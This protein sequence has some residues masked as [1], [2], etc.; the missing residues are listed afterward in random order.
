MRLAVQHLWM[1]QAG[2]TRAN[3]TFGFSR[4]TAERVH[5]L[6]QLL[7]KDGLPEY[8]KKII[9]E[10]SH[11]INLV[12]DEKDAIG[13]RYRRQDAIGTPYCITIDHQTI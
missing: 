12:Y 3:L 9:S 6:P 2:A 8:A 4:R 5:A 11:E 1:R 10:F 7:K 13:R